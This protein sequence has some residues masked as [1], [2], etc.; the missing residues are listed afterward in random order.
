MECFSAHL[1]Q[2]SAEYDSA[3]VLKEKQIETLSYLYKG[4]DVMCVLPTGYGKSVI[5]HVLP[6]LLGL[7]K[8]IDNSIVIVVSPLNAIIQDQIRKLAKKKV[9]ACALSLDAQLQT[10]DSFFDEETAEDTLLL[11]NRS[12]LPE[13]RAGHY[14]LVFAHPEA[15]LSKEGQSVMATQV[16][17]DH[18]TA[19]VIDEA[20]CIEQW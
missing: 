2:S 20:H 12:D 7:G 11:N 4:T 9:A 13:L 6:R 14:P 15:L 10:C 3:L 16:F 17:Q 8:G 5:F 18:V 19:V 1:Q